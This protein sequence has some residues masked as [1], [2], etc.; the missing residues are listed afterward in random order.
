MTMQKSAWRI[1]CLDVVLLFKYPKRIIYFVGMIRTIV[2][3][4]S[5]FHNDFNGIWMY[6]DVESLQKMALGKNQFDTNHIF[7]ARRSIE[8]FPMF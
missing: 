3:N 4:D 7:Y 8:Y 1:F 2:L 5:P 6:H